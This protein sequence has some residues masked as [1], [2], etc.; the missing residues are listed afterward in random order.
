MYLKIYLPVCD[1]ECIDLLKVQFVPKL[2]SGVF[3]LF[4]DIDRGGGLILLPTFVIRWDVVR[5]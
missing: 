4:Q 2:L 1:D 5:V 3:L